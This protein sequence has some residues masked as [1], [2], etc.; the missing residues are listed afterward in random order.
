MP[1]RPATQA[2]SERGRANSAAGHTRANLT[3]QPDQLAP[4]AA[5]GYPTSRIAIGERVDVPG[6][7]ASTDTMKVLD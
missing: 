1:Q 6:A 3:E 4:G 7:Y 5:R 2:A